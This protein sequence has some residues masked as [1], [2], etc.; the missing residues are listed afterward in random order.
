MISRSSE[1]KEKELKCSFAF[2]VLRVRVF[3]FVRRSRY[4]TCSPSSR[5]EARGHFT[6][7]I[8]QERG[9]SNKRANPFLK[10]KNTLHMSKYRRN[11][12]DE[13]Y[14]KYFVQRTVNSS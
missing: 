7:P 4:T 12:L 10:E 6:K 13:T 2:C 11:S 14:E 8:V 9:R 5:A 3:G 1:R